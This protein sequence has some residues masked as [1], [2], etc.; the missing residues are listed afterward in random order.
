MDLFAA[1]RFHALRELTF[2]GVLSERIRSFD[3]MLDYSLKIIEILQQKEDS[4]EVHPDGYIH[5]DMTKIEKNLM[6]RAI[7]GLL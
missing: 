7:K 5:R 3:K 1:E 4:Q 2:N 6:N